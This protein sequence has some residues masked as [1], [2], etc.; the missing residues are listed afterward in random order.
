MKE[1]LQTSITVTDRYDGR[2]C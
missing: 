2:Q 1:T